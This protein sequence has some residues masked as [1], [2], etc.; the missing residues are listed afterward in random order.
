MMPFQGGGRRRGW[1]AKYRGSAPIGY[2]DLMHVTGK[3][4]TP[5]RH[6]RVGRGRLKE[7]VLTE[8]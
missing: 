2:S 3:G 6:L 4:T 8:Q 5:Q 1:L 7:P